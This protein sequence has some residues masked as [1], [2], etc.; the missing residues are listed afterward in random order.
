MT[1]KAGSGG[2]ASEPGQQQKPRQLS[3]RVDY[4]VSSPACGIRF[5][6]AY[7]HTHAQV[8][9]KCRRVPSQLTLQ[10]KAVQMQQRRRRPLVWR[11]LTTQL[12][13]HAFRCACTVFVQSGI[14]GASAS[15]IIQII[16]LCMQLRRARAWVPCV[17]TPGAGCPVDLAITVA[18]CAVLLSKLRWHANRHL[19]QPA[20]RV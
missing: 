14:A 6:G 7:A 3:V 19:F 13:V 10:G 8:P 2:G 20:L 18:R 16:Y 17:D 5:W 15:S 4:A 9:S 11:L 1:G 12:T